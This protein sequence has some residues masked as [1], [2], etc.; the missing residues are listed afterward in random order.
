MQDEQL[1]RNAVDFC[2]RVREGFLTD[3][4]STEQALVFLQTVRIHI[5]LGFT[6]TC[7]T[8]AFISDAMGS[9]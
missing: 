2:G 1:L 8:F 3:K 7:L 6:T 4:N 5:I 9:S